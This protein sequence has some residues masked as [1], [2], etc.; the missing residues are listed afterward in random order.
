MITEHQILEELQTCKKPLFFFHDDADG[1]C[2]FLLLYRLSNEGKGIVVKASDGVNET[3]V[4]KVE[5]Y[6][7]DKIFI[8]DLAIVSP[9]FLRRV[10]VPVIW[11]DHHPLSEDLEYDK[12]KFYNP[13]LKDPA[14][15]IPA[16]KLCYDIVKQD[17]WIAGIG[18]IGDWVLIP[19]F[20][21]ELRKNHPKLLSEEIKNP[22]DALFSSEFGKLAKIFTFILQ[23]KT[24]DINKCVKVLT[25]IKTPEEIL[26]QTTPQGKFIYKKY[27][28][29]A[30]PYEEL[31]ARAIKHATKD[32]FLVFSYTLDISFTG[33]LANEL[34]YKYPDKIIII[35]REK[36]GWM[37]CSLRSPKDINV[38]KLLQ[39]SLA[40]IEG[41]GG[42]HEHAC[43]ASVKKEQWQT[44]LE[45]MKEN[46]KS[47]K[48]H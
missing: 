27:E 4:H 1:L 20:M 40:G 15:N 5:E 14:L 8:T 35:S 44:F 2:S 39:L 48:I 12:A 36:S 37:R 21:D 3:F 17:L 10:K 31:L 38:S 30:K 34:L 43:G 22:G 7:P 23:G 6:N 25:R 24:S 45:N 33:E 11:I 19:E 13:R 41:K 28:K 9:E 46:L 42:G 18:V 29:M 26:E 16:T 47:A 32:K